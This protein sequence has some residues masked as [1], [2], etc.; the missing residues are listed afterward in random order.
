MQLPVQWAICLFVTDTNFV[1]NYII[2]MGYFGVKS[3]IPC[4]PRQNSK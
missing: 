4:K 3:A 2:I 1:L